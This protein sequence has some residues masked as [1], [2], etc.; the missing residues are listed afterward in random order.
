M[1][2]CALMPHRSG[3]GLPSNSMAVPSIDFVLTGQ[4]RFCCVELTDTCRPGSFR[5]RFLSYYK[6]AMQISSSLPP[7]RNPLL[8]VMPSQCAQYPASVNES[9][10]TLLNDTTQ[11]VLNLV[12]PPALDTDAV[13]S[14]LSN[15]YCAGT[16][17]VCYGICSNADLAGIGVRIA[18][19]LS[20]TLQGIHVCYTC[21]TDASSLTGISAP[22]CSRS[23]IPR[24]FNARWCVGL[25]Y[26]Y[27]HDYLTIALQI[28]LDD[29]RINSFHCDTSDNTKKETYAH[30]LPCHART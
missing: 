17:T 25:L 10:T 12:L 29:G 28:S 1:L 15:I 4:T 11:S 7:I 23:Y 13:N 22:S 21:R 19:W 3:K 16:T 20:S 27:K 2:G 18:F 24:R 30:A 14:L 6:I 26:K 9:L 8:Q 5:T